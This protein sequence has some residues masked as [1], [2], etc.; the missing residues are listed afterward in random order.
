MSKRFLFILLTFCALVG[1]VA[2]GSTPD[3]TETTLVIPTIPN[4]GT[5]PA[6][7]AQAD[8]GQGIAPT[9][10][11]TLSDG[12]SETLQ[13]TPTLIPELP[14]TEIPPVPDTPAATAVLNP[15]IQYNRA[16]PPA[17]Q[18]LIFI[19][20]GALKLWNHNN[21]QVEIL[22]EGG[23]AT[24]TTSRQSANDLLVGDIHSYSVSSNGRSLVANRVTLV[25]T[26]TDL[27][28]Y[29][30]ELISL[31]L[32][33]RQPHTIA[34]S[35]T[36]LREFAISPNGEQVAYAARTPGATDPQA[37]TLWLAALPSG[38]SRTIATC[39]GGCHSL[40]WHPESNLFLWND[41]TALW[42]QNLT[43]SKPE[44]LITNHVS[45]T[46]A[47]NV[48]VYSAISWSHNGR[49]LLAWEGYYEGGSRV[50]IDIPT[51]AILP[52]PNTEF[53]AGANF[54]DLTWMQDDRLF[55]LRPGFENSQVPTAE[56]W[57]VSPDERKVVLEESKILGDSQFS[58]I[59]PTH[60]ADGR[61]AYALL[62][63]TN[64][65]T[66]GLYLLTAIAEQPQRVNAILP[67]ATT[68][69]SQVVWLADGSGALISQSNAT[70]FAVANNQNLY[71]I[72]PLL[73]QYPHHF[74]WLPT[75]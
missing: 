15:A 23:T 17:S 10:T 42:L 70:L 8:S 64:N 12:T 54:T 44:V 11:L 14:A 9:A 21:G 26:A 40:A 13:A 32:D 22:L 43:A 45:A 29:Q 20:D 36:G 65:P 27:E 16:L 75:R 38:T 73:G 33:D 28:T 41:Q 57:R 47:S 19:A 53:Y 61:F 37:Q 56:L 50:V 39:T 4:S 2:C 72:Q 1:L 48:R 35:L 7:T 30:Y 25:G 59:S 62:S 68:W 55:V 46:D 66:A 63:A 6:S 18:D 24:A 69:D 49:F 67:T 51:K 52:I 71:D 34:T 5:I 3:T 31:N 58:T 60:L 74:H